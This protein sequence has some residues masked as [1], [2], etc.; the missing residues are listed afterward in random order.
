MTEQKLYKPRKDSYMYSFDSQIGKL[1]GLSDFLSM[2]IDR[3]SKEE[4][5]MDRDSA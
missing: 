4:K 3:Q 1:K 5:L 2:R